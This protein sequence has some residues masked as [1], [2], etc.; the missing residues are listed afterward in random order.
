MS[1]NFAMFGEQIQKH[2]KPEKALRVLTYHGARKA[3]LNPTEISNYDVVITTYETLMIEL[4]PRNSKVA[5]QVPS[6]EGYALRALL[7]NCDECD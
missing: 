7:I 2:L 3:P 1:T 6:K 5:I 4:F